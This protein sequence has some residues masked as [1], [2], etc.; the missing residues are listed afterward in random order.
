[1]LAIKNSQSDTVRQMLLQE[2]GL[3]SQK[4]KSEDAKFDPDVELDA[5]KFLGAYLGSITPLHFAILLGQ[6]E[7]AKDIIERSFKEDLEET[8]GVR[9]C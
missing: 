3:A 5:Y 9:N 7:I 1:M 2:K 6:D 4:Y 8:F